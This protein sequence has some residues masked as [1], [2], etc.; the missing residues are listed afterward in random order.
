MADEITIE[1][2]TGDTA[3]APEALSDEQKTFLTEH[4]ADL[5]DE[6]ATKYS[7]EKP[8]APIEPVVR[9]EDDKGKKKDDDDDDTLP[10]DKEAINK[11]VDAKLTPI[12]QKI[13]H[14]T[15]V[16]EANNFV[17]AHP[18]YSKYREAIIKH[19]EH[20]AY[21]NIPV[22]RIA[23]IVAG[24]D[25]EKIGAQKEREAAAKAAGTKAGGSTVRQQ[26]GGGK[27]WS[28]ATPAEVAAQRAQVLGQGSR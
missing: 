7:I 19:M 18:E 3:P 17:I 12:Q 14:Q 28:T 9:N 6:V 13:D 25:L 22:D 23:F 10:E 24:P 2:F 8:T 1:T 11:V 26:S 15:N 5:T 16:M 20:P 27:D 21:K 4:A